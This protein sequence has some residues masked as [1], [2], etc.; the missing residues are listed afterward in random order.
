M[1]ARF[2]FPHLAALLAALTA[3]G[4]LSALAGVVLWQGWPPAALWHAVFALGAMPL[5]FA[6]MIYFTPVLT[7]TP[8]PPRGLALWPL[9]ALAAGAGIVAR[10]GHGV[11]AMR[12][13][14]PWLALVAVG[15]L[16][17]W[18]FRRRRACLGP[19]HACLRW[20][21]SALGCLA[22]GLAAVAVSAV[23][24]DWAPPL[25]AFHLH[26]N[27]LGFMGLAALGTL[28]VLLPTVLGKPDPGAPRRLA[29]D[30]PW[31]LAGALGI[32][33]GAAMD[34]TPGRT[35]AMVATAAYGW[36]LLRLARDMH[37]TFGRHLWTP[38]Q[39]APLLLAAMTGLAL[40]LLHGLAHVADPGRA[41]DVLPPFLIAFLLPLVSGATAQLLPVWLRPGAQADWHKSQRWR[42][43]AFART[44]AALF[45]AAGL[46][47]A[48]GSGTGYLFGMLGAIWLIGAMAL[49]VAGL[50]RPPP[51][52]PR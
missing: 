41:R 47:A 43:A 5:I 18:M 3:A 36:P 52:Q 40:V 28:Q 38:R 6:A 32:A 24:P 9:A 14:A 45:P 33:I 30:L 25:R 42:L 19:P 12:Q 23:R 44:R 39:P 26:I 21:A 7:R 48:T 1:S 22:L 29:R 35:L 15:G 31:S 37:V 10:F 4:G 50:I 2:R 13:A 51:R 17:Y 49:T 27:T 8:E 20:Y 11:E 46:L 34:D 16:G